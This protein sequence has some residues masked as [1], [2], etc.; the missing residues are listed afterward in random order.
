MSENT[1]ILSPEGVTKAER[2]KFGKAQKKLF[3]IASLDTENTDCRQNPIDILKENS[4]GRMQSLLP[5][6][7]ERMSASPFSFYRGSAAAG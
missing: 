7:S 5:L 6:C 1:F 4:A 2:H 3:P